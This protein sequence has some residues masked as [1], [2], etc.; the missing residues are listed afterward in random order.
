MY[1]VLSGGPPSTLTVIDC[2]RESA[3]MLPVKAIDVPCKS[4]TIDIVLN[5]SKNATYLRRTPQM[6]RRKLEHWRAEEMSRFH[7]TKKAAR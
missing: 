4:H 1:D 7:R 2:E 3:D 6:S 5:G